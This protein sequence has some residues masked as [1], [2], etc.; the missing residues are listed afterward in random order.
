MEAASVR[1]RQIRRS[2]RERVSSVVGGLEDKYYGPGA[3]ICPERRSFR[4]RSGSQQSLPSPSLLT[5]FRRSRSAHVVEERKER[6]G[7]TMEVTGDGGESLATFLES[8]G[9]LSYHNAI[10]DELR[11]E[12][13]QQLKQVEEQDLEDIRMKPE[14]IQKLK[15]NMKKEFPRSAFGKLKKMSAINAVTR[16]ISIKRL[17]RPTSEM[18]GVR[19]SR[20][21]V[22]SPELDS[23]NSPVPIVGRRII[24]RDQIDVQNDIGEGEFGVVRH[25]IYTND[26]EQKIPVAVKSLSQDRLEHGLQEFLKEASSMQSVSHSNIV[27]FYGIVFQQDKE[28]MLVTEYA[29]LKS[30]LECLHNE[31]LRSVLS[32]SRLCTFAHQIATGMTYLETQGLIHRDLAAR[33]ILVFSHH[34]VKIGDFGLS[35]ALGLDKEYYQSKYRTDLK[36]PIAWCAPECINLLRFSSASDVWAFGV[37]LW[38]MFTYGKKP[39]DGLTSMEILK[40]IDKPKNER[41]PRPD[42][43]PTEHYELMQRCWSHDPEDR[44]KFRSLTS[45]LTSIKPTL[46]RTIRANSPASGVINF[47][48]GDTLTVIDKKPADSP[49]WQYWLGVNKKGERGFFNPSDCV[50]VQP[51]SSPVTSR[52]N[53]SLQPPKSP[54]NNFLK[55][56]KKQSITKSPKSQEKKRF[57][58]DMIGTPQ[59]DLRHTGHIGYDGITFGDISFI[60]S[61][62]VEK[63]LPIKGSGSGSSTLKS[64]HSAGS[65]STT[66]P[67]N[68]SVTNASVP[69]TTHISA[70]V[71][72][73][74]SLQVEAIRISNDEKEFGGDIEDLSD[75]QFPDL[76]L[77]ESLNFGTSFIDDMMRDFKSAERNDNTNEN[78]NSS[79]HLRN[80]DSASSQHV[81]AHAASR[82]NSLTSDDSGSVS[83]SSTQSYGS[84]TNGL[85]SSAT[86]G[87]NALT[88]HTNTARLE[89]ASPAFDDSHG[90]TGKARKK[91]KHKLVLP[92]TNLKSMSAA[93]EK[94]I[95]D[96]I[97]L[98]NQL[99]S[100]SLSQA[101]TPRE[102]EDQPETPS[103]SKH[104][105]HFKFPGTKK[106]SPKSDKKT[107]SDSLISKSSCSTITPEAEQVYNMLI[108]PNNSTASQEVRRSHPVHPTQRPPEVPTNV[109]RTRRH[110]SNSQTSNRSSR[111]SRGLE[112]PK[113][114]PPLPP[115]HLATGSL[116]SE[117]P[118][119]LTN[120]PSTPPPPVP[121]SPSRVTVE[122]VYNNMEP[123]WRQE[124]N[125]EDSKGSKFTH[126]KYKSRSDNVSYEDLMDIS[127][128]RQQI[129]QMQ[130]MLGK[131]VS[132]SD[133]RDALERTDRQIQNAI[134]YIK[135]K[136]LANLRLA[137]MDQCKTALM[138]CQW[139][140]QRAADYILDRKVTYTNDVIGV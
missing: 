78:N 101:N 28:L 21:S 34:K 89:D 88:T 8:V 107:F 96:A 14:D 15:R 85:P 56:I 129:R 9:L 67:S 132:E 115:I 104:K 25:A 13:V 114:K 131:E 92:G 113:E 103:K 121:Q 98:A 90:N 124:I 119:D 71:V 63:I 140:V 84:H 58:A 51:E 43:C 93:D 3:S 139:S 122:P 105:F 50:P 128:E 136:Q 49:S 26:I 30:L 17:T 83:H 66:S 80:G 123:F 116:E 117:N 31:S 135:L 97:E 6:A 94:M 20:S 1:I 54:I 77:S 100:T 46:M 130:R 32:V 134:K 82:T 125:S 138:S 5:V 4:S 2:V 10:R 60:G 57:T 40:S 72:N 111:S 65:S 126:G 70:P 12:T 109:V 35:R 127:E 118:D 24:S 110:S 99:A 73:G 69:V 120:M 102:P 106:T 19:G 7:N 79:K 108:G 48:E 53:T 44:P 62:P 27:T 137:G 52:Q 36:I 112:R 47:A 42:F 29:P 23:P 95:N 133:C 75:F 68:D 18:A 33:N 39:W 91:P 55:S 59:N 81:S 74:G 86:S 41:L 16:R 11:V 87:T 37:T 61:D 22:L 76:N 45:E 38:E 64:S